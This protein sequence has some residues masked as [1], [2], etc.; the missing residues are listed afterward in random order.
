MPFQIF[1]WIGLLFLLVFSYIPMFGI[2][3]AFKN[4]KIS[5]G[6][7]G[8]FSS[9]WAGFSHFKEL[10]NDYNFPMLVRNTLVLSILKVI[11]SYPIPILFAIILSEVRHVFVKRFV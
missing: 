5:T 7:D 11:F 8:I 9:S 4:Y 1:V 2:I 10:I 6:I 3:I